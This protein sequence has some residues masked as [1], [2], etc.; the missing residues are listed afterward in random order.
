MALDL[1]SAVAASTLAANATKV[2]DSLR[3]K[4]DALRK[5]DSGS[6]I[7]VKVSELKDR[8][9]EFQKRRNGCRC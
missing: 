3:S 8:F 1:V 7:E 2:A 4:F 9:V 5:K 6:E